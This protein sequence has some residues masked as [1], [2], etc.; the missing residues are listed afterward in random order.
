VG[1]KGNDGFWARLFKG[2][3]KQYGRKV[4][5]GLLLVLVGWAAFIDAL[6]VAGVEATKALE[7]L[8][9]FL[10]WVGGIVVVGNMSEHVSKGFGGKEKVTPPAEEPPKA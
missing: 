1:E 7:L 6:H 10:Q 2:L 8:F 3:A 9:G 4:A 5:F